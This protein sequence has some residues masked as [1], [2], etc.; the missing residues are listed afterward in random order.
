MA[1]NVSIEFVS[2]GPIRIITGSFL[3]T[4]NSATS[5]VTLPAG[6]TL[7]TN[8]VVMV[9]PAP[10]SLAGAIRCSVY[11]TSANTFS[12]D[13]GAAGGAGPPAVAY[14]CNFVIFG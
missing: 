14:T 12:V 9:N 4:P 6:I 3:S 10:A 11:A 7:T 13:F 8:S 2:N 5:V 1:T